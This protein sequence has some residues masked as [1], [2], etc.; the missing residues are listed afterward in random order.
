[1]LI[2]YYIKLISGALGFLCI[3]V[4]LKNRDISCFPVPVETS[5]FDII[6]HNITLLG[7]NDLHS[8]LDGVGLQSYPNQIQGG[9]SKLVHLINNIRF[10]LF[11]LK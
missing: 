10:V 5:S 4:F 9:Y 1:M 11:C 3:A 6:V 7:T 2:S 8:S